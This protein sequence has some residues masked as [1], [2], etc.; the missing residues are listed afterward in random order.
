MTQDVHELLK[1]R[2]ARNDNPWAFYSPA[3]AGRKVHFEKHIGSVR[4]AT[5]QPL[6]APEWL[7]RVAYMI[8]GT[9]SKGT[10]PVQASSVM[11][12]GTIKI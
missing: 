7:L 4:K 2:A 10:A 11:A 5:M 9:Q 6:R 1:P 12:V 3:G 8:P